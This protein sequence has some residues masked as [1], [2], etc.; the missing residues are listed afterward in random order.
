MNAVYIKDS[1]QLIANIRALIRQ[2]Q[3]TCLNND[4]IPEDAEPKVHIMVL[5]AD[6]IPENYHQPGFVACKTSCPTNAKVRENQWL[7][8]VETQFHSM[9]LEDKILEGESDYFNEFY[10]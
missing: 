5:Y 2:I 7:G 9:K 8:H 3:T 10:E 6:N 1:K 4:A